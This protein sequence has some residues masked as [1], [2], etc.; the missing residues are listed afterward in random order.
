MMAT[1]DSKFCLRAPRSHGTRTIHVT[2][3]RHE[4]PSAQIIRVI[5]GKVR[6]LLSGR[7]SS[8]SSQGCHRASRFSPGA[9]RCASHP[10]CFASPLPRTVRGSL[11]TML[12]AQH[13]PSR[14]APPVLEGSASCT[15]LQMVQPYRCHQG[16]SPRA[17]SGHERGRAPEAQGD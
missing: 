12:Q 10:E 14:C 16:R 9:A 4:S 6:Y 17:G 8:A 7:P 2:A 15:P 11:G 3:T 1:V 5:P 13:G